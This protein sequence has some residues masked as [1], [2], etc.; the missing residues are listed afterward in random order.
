MKDFFFFS[1]PVL[2]ILLVGCDGSSDP[3]S[4][5]PATSGVVGGAN[6]EYVGGFAGP[7]LPADGTCEVP[8]IALEGFVPSSGMGGFTPPKV[9]KYAVATSNVLLCGTEFPDG[10]FSNIDFSQLPFRGLT[11]QELAADIPAAV[12]ALSSVEDRSGFSLGPCCESVVPVANSGGYVQTTGLI[13]G[14]FAVRSEVVAT[15]KVLCSISGVFMG[16]ACG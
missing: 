9:L 14:G 5:P 3:G 10:S 15:L 12:S 4:L 6:L 16:W 7:Y 13:C 2:A 8:A 1:T 11:C